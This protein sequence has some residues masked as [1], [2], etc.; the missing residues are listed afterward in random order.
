MICDECGGR[1]E[2]QINARLARLAAFDAGWIRQERRRRVIGAWTDNW[3]IEERHICPECA[4]RATAE[5]V[6]EGVAR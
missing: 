4:D 2:P 6:L 5:R 3:L 1:S